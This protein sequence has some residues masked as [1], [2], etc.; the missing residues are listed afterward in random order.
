MAA[1]S[2]FLPSSIES[3]AKRE[4]PSMCQKSKCRRIRGYFNPYLI[5]ERR[6]HGILRSRI[7]KTEVEN[8][9]SH[10]LD[11]E[12]TFSLDGNRDLNARSSPHYCRLL[13]SLRLPRSYFLDVPF[14]RKT[15]LHERSSAAKAC[16]H[17]LCRCGGL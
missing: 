5:V 15:P 8:D 4:Q 2:T 10:T 14:R 13:A 1:I 12:E 3:L 9:F 17:P 7:S 6:L 11:H 16:C